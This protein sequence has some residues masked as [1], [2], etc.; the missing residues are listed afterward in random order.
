MKSV[1]KGRIPGRLRNEYARFDE[2]CSVLY[3]CGYSTYQIADKLNRSQ[4]AVGRSL[5]RSKTPR[6]SNK[7]SQLIRAQLG[8]AA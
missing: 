8:R 6:R 1:N 4:G 2:R 3:Q 7:E 5:R